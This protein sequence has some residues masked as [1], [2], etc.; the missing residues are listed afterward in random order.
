MLDTHTLLRRH[1][2]AVWYF[3][4]PPLTQTHT[5]VP[6]PYQPPWHLCIATLQPT[7]EQLYIWRSD[8]TPQQGEQLL[9]HVRQ[10]QAATEVEAVSQ[11]VSASREVALVQTATPAMDLAEARRLARR[12]LPDERH[13]IA[14]F[15]PEDV[16]YFSAPQQQPV[17]GVVEHDR[18]VSVAHSSR[19]TPDACELD[20][21]TL[22]EARRKGYALAATLLWA[23]AITQEGLLPI[24][25]ALA[26]NHAS[27]RLAHCA[28]YR[29][30][31]HA[32]QLTLT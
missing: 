9:Q 30:F 18:L 31:A 13:I 11:G 14:T 7:N 6:A 12:I 3:Q 22:P 17:F 4:I 8:V 32:L 26:S 25:S 28:G 20:I 5:I 1:L 24:Y 2:E 19:H 27:L 29:P 16:D 15:L 10:L 21:E 23:E